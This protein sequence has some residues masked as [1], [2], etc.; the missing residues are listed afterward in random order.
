MRTDAHRPSAIVPADYQFV[1]YEY[2]PVD[3]MD[4]SAIAF[5]AAERERIRAHMKETGGKYSGHQH[6]GNCHVCGSVNAIYTTLFFH[7]PTCSYIRTGLDCTVKLDA[8]LDGEEFRRQVRGALEQVAGK[9]KA[10]ALLEQAGHA[11]AWP[12]Y[13]KFLTTEAPREEAI[14]TEMIGKLVK[15]GNITEKQMAYIGTL[16]KLIDTRAE[17]EA[18]RATEHA[19]AAPVP[20]IDARLTITGR[21]ATIKRTQPY[22]FDPTVFVLQMMVIAP[23][24][25]KL[26]GKLPKDLSAAK[27]GDTVKFD[28]RVKPSRNDPKFG[29]F[30]RPTKAS[31]I[32]PAT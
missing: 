13:E 10:R 17:R 7:K 25:F 31:I 24:G 18:Q 32:Q 14:I 2:L 19:A 26:W 4:F 29:Y 8:S 30:S 21:I 23:E 3:P 6:G 12:I 5:L 9:K 16:L 15:Y 1:A 11:A 27:A 28:C 22:S 20:V